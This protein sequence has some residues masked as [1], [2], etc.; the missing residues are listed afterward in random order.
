MVNFCRVCSEPYEDEDSDSLEPE[1]YC[2]TSCEELDAQLDGPDE[3]VDDPNAHEC[4]C[5]DCCQFPELH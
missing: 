5:L 4:C 1:T 2:S 3:E